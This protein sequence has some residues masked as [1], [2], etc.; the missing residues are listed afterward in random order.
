MGKTIQFNNAGLIKVVGILK[1]V[2]DN[3][4]FPL[5]LIFGYRSLVNVDFNDWQGTYS[6]GYTFVRLSPRTSVTGFNADL[7]EL[8][9]RHTPPGRERRGVVAQPLA[10]MHRDGQF[11]NFRG[12]T[13]GAGLTRSLILIAA[14]LLMIACVNFVNMATAQAVRRARETGIRK[15]LGSSRRQL[16]G[17]FIGESAV[18]SVFAM[19][20]A[21]SLAAAALPVLNSLLGIHLRLKLT[22]GYLLVFLLLVTAA[23]T[24]MAGIY[25]A[26]ILSAFKPVDTLKN[27]STIRKT[28]G[29]SLRRGLVVLQFGIAQVLIICMLVVSGQLHFFQHTALG[30]DPSGVVNVPIPGD[31]VSQRKMETVRQELLQ[32]PGVQQVSF[33]TFSPLDNDI[34]SN[35]FKFDHSGTPTNFQAFFK[36]ADA[37][38]FSLYQPEF[39]AGR[40]Y[41]PG[42]T[43][44]EYVVNE[45]L[46]RQLGLRGPKDILGKEISFFDQVRGPVVGVVKDFFTNSLQKP[47]TPIVMA[48]WKDTYAMAGIKLRTAQASGRAG[49]AQ[50]LAAIERIWRTAYPDFLY[51]YQFLEEKI[52]SYY[53]E[54]EKLSELYQVFAGIAIFISCLG[55]YGLISFMAA[56]RRKEIGVRKVVGASVFDVVVL[57][58]REFTWLVGAAF[59]VAAPVAYLLTHRWLEAFAYRIHPGAGIFLVTIAASL[60]ITWTTVGYKTFLAA[61]ANPAAALRSE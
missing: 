51:S 25:P 58:S 57:L 43:V 2:P 39:I 33:S 47:I 12:R 45:T 20:V 8:M 18:V 6:R 19:V 31:S 7:R 35:Q 52:G 21:L 4:D 3:T 41:G 55:L 23:T 30:F 49:A 29:L 53:Q 37:N 60:L 27:S 26:F 28:G 5:K 50:T 32:L 13:F 38:F 14:F 44:R 54:E 15:V 36:W 40:A 11:G 9:D 1:D 59:A 34:W 22:D 17:Q 10:E 24:M 48:C 16:I 56:Q 46:V 61:L 42:D